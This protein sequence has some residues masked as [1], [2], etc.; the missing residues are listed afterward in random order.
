[1]FALGS[2]L[3]FCIGRSISSSPLAF[4]STKTSGEPHKQSHVHMTAVS[5]RVPPK[6]LAACLQGFLLFSIVV[7]VHKNTQVKAGQVVGQ[8]SAFPSGLVDWQMGT[9]LL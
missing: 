8:C 9:R 4:T 3:F 6:R 7:P 1:M 5:V 2:R